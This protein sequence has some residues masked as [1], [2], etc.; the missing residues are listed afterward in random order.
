MNINIG[1]SDDQVNA[2]NADC[3]GAMRIQDWLRLMINKT[4]GLYDNRDKLKCERCGYEWL[5]RKERPSYCS[6]CKS[7]YWRM[8]VQSMSLYPQLHALQVGETC[9]LPWAKRRPDPR[10]MRAVRYAMRRHGKKFFIESKG[11][12]LVVTRQPDTKSSDGELPI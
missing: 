11:S 5:P 8:P 3:K 12:G 2:I 9:T 7:P 1:L 10:P 6:K 4:L